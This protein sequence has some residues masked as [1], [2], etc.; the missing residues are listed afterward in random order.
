MLKEIYAC[1]FL[2]S[3]KTN[4]RRALHKLQFLLLSISAIKELRG[5][6]FLSAMHFSSCQKSLSKDM[7]VECPEITIE[8]FSM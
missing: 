7:L 8:C 4:K 1:E 6:P 2:I 3:C 5:T